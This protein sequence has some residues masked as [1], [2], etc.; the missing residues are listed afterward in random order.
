M[1]NKT[2]VLIIGSWYSTCSSCGHGASPTESHHTT[3]LGYGTHPPDG[4]GAEF[5]AVNAE[6]G[7][8]AEPSVR[9]MRPDLPYSE[10]REV[11]PDK[12]H[13]R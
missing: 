4:C 12:D 11:V 6:Y 9:A 2:A 8:E 13:D 5:V 7:P 1:S 3:R 10:S